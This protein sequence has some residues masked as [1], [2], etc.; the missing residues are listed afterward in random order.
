MPFSVI[1][2]QNKAEE[3]FDILLFCVPQEVKIIKAVKSA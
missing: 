2:T 1:A 3:D